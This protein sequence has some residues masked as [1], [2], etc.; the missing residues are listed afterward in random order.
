[1][2]QHFLYILYLFKSLLSI[3]DSIFTCLISP[4][5]FLNKKYSFSLRLCFNKLG[6]YQLYLITYSLF[7]IFLLFVTLFLHFYFLFATLFLHVYFLHRSFFA[8]S[9]SLSVHL[10]FYLLSICDPALLYFLSWPFCLWRLSQATSV[11][12]KK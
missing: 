7:P 11:T 12:S 4:K 2:F 5:V 6:S 10:W 1:M 8:R 3:C 9:H